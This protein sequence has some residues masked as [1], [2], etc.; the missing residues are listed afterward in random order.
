MRE[1]DKKKLS[2]A[3]RSEDIETSVS[4]SDNEDG[5]DGE[6][7]EKVKLDVERFLPESINSK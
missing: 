1:E 5:Y 2:K 4:E 6:T 3:A 7:A